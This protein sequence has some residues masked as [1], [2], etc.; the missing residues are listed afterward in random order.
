LVGVLAFLGGCAI[1][2][3]IRDEHEAS[4][5]NRLSA[6]ER[7][8]LLNEHNRVRRDVGHPPLHWSPEIARF[9]QQWADHLASSCSM[10]HRPKSGRWAQ[11]YGENLFMGT[12]GYYTVASAVQGWESEKKDFRGGKITVD[13][14]FSRIG[15]YTQ[16]IWRRTTT[17]GCGKSLC[18]D[19]MIVVCNYDPP[20]NFI[21]RTPFE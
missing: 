10:Q 19:R 4:G 5:S 18:R 7:R 15:H 16:L 1:A 20:G 2:S 14:N 6:S 11:R 12:A 3:T 8:A 17:L 13:R 21:G 9:S